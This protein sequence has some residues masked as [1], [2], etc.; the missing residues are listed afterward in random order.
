MNKALHNHF[1]ATTAII[2]GGASGIGQGLAEEV[3]KLGC[4]VVIADMQ[5]ELASEVAENIRRS[6]GSASAE[7]LDVRDADAF[8]KLLERTRAKTGRIDYLF[9]NAGI[10]ISG[11]VKDYALDDWQRI[12][13]INL[14]GVINGIQAAYPMM[15]EQGAG[16]II[17]TS[18]MAGVTPSP[19]LAGYSATKHAVVGLSNALRVEAAFEGVRVSVMCPGTVRTPLLG[20]GGKYGKQL[21]NISEEESLKAWEK[22]MPMDVN[23]YAKKA[24]KAIARNQAIII[25]PSWYRLLWF[26]IRLSPLI[27]MKLSASQFKEQHISTSTTQ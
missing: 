16:H 15:I 5:L 26:I 8:L 17:N 21:S 20:N 12:V 19:G 7:K 23:T 4:T 13:D 22:L 3:A 2:T 18:S 14:M 11:A 6:G 10:C 24:L 25:Y 27:I 9:N 1:Q